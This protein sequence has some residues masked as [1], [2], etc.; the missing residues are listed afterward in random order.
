MKLIV[1]T[2]VVL[3]IMQCR[4]PHY[5]MSSRCLSAVLHGRAVACLPAHTATTLYYLLNKF[6]DAATARSAIRWILDT[7]NVV[8]CDGKILESAWQSKISDF[9]DAVVA[10][11]AQ[12]GGCDYVITRD[13]P[14]FSGS[15]VQALTPDAFVARWGN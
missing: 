1:D 4:Q 10:I 2:N 3:D 13:L 6:S 9:E 8:P 15:P 11:S 14:G 7:F 12:Y 5:E